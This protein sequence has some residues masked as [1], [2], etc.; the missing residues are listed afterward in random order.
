MPADLTAVEKFYSLLRPIQGAGRGKDTIKNPEQVYSAWLGAAAQLPSY[1]ELQD[2][3]SKSFFANR[4]LDPESTRYLGLE[5]ISGHLLEQDP[6]AREQSP[7]LDILKMLIAKGYGQLPA[8][9]HNSG[10]PN[11]FL[12]FIGQSPLFPYWAEQQK[13]EPFQQFMDGAQLDAPNIAWILREKQALASDPQIFITLCLRLG[14]AMDQAI[15]R[16]DWSGHKR[17]PQDNGISIEKIALLAGSL[18]NY[19]A[20]MP[21]EIAM[22]GWY[23][24][25]GKNALLHPQWTRSVFGGSPNLREFSLPDA[26]D[27]HRPGSTFME[28]SSANTEA[29]EQDIGLFQKMLEQIPYLGDISSEL[30][31]LDSPSLFSLYLDHPSISHGPRFNHRGHSL[32]I[33]GPLEKNQT[34]SDKSSKYLAGVEECVE[35]IDQLDGNLATFD[36]YL[37]AK[38]G[39]SLDTVKKALRLSYREKSTKHIS[40]AWIVEANRPEL[41]A[42]FPE[43]QVPW[44]QVGA[45]LPENSMSMGTHGIQA[46]DT[47]WKNVLEGPHGKSCERGYICAR[48]LEQKAEAPKFVRQHPW[49]RN[50][51]LDEA[52]LSTR[53]LGQL[54]KKVNIHT[55]LETA[56]A[57]SLSP[58]TMAREAYATDA[59]KESY[60]PKESTLLELIA[61]ANKPNFLL[62]YRDLGGVFASRGLETAIEANKPQN[63]DILLTAPSGIMDKKLPEKYL[64]KIDDRISPTFLK[65]V[66][67]CQ[68]E[69]LSLLRALSGQHHHAPDLALLYGL[70]LEQ[71]DP[72]GIFTEMV[73]QGGPICELHPEL[74]RQSIYHGADPSRPVWVYDYNGF[75]QKSLP[76]LLPQIKGSQGSDLGHELLAIYKSQEKSRKDLRQQENLEI[77][78]F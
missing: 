9:G 74:L 7:L 73:Q 48:I 77:E 3:L 49:M 32:Q 40:F 26:I 30:S 63:L 28:K 10:Y 64:E 13:P 15:A 65:L 62:R 35:K 70:I 36:F 66:K 19:T 68:P 23:G 17:P 59:I 37:L 25:V 54:G 72:Q 76:D 21:P 12:Q 1:P 2:Q 27:H 78:L 50:L 46:A 11:P 38:S 18:G 14:K 24:V 31:N 41:L 20:H 56:A 34:K 33:F 8:K 69:P 67:I 47:P 75:S 58:A 71:N 51:K 52:V 57:L 4:H 6:S 53:L 45:H 29:W 5:S 55:A 44:T 42:L 39:A 61:A 60:A 22:E 16:K 43:Q